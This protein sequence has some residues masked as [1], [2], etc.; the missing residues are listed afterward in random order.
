MSG[1][2][3]A[4]VAGLDDARTK[5]TPGCSAE[6]LCGGR[7]V[8]NGGMLCGASAVLLGAALLTAAS[9][10]AG[11]ASS[12]TYLSTSIRS[13]AGVAAV[14]IV[15]AAMV[16]A[17]RVDAAKVVAAR[18]VA[19]RAVVVTRRGGINRGERCTSGTGGRIDSAMDVGGLFM[20]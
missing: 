4:S 1:G 3:D 6:A 8:F 7:S 19:A 2:Y 14:M 10:P 9:W 18:V 15:D 16:D 5:A 11:I 20:R 13:A 17:A 12:S